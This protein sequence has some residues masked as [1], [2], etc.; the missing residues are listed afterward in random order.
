MFILRKVVIVGETLLSFPVKRGIL[1]P[2]RK[3]LPRYSPQD[4]KITTSHLST[5]VTQNINYVIDY[6]IRENYP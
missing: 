2:K 1:E 4:D 3:I 6:I 5:S